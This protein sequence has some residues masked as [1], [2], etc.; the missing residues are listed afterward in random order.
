MKYSQ[1]FLTLTG[2]SATS[3]FLGKLVIFQITLVNFHIIS[4]WRKLDA[5]L[6]EKY[7]QDSPKKIFGKFIFFQVS[8]AVSTGVLRQ[9]IVKSTAKK[10]SLKLLK[11]KEIFDELLK[12]H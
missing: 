5:S 2:Y 12:V 10:D 6:V 7:S 11:Q 3:M 1:T 8:R 9:S 4:N